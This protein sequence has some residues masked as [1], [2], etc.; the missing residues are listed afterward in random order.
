MATRLFFALLLLATGALQAQ[1]VVRATGHPNWPPFSWQQGDK[2]VGIGAELTELVFKDLGLT[3]SS[4]AHGNWKRAQL[5]VE[6]GKVDVIVAAYF[7]TERSKVM[8][9]P[10]QPYMNDANVLWVSKDNVFPFQQWSDLVDKTGTAMLG[11]SYGEAFDL[12]IKER[13][14]VEWVST[15]AQ[16]LGKLELGRADY[17]PFS[18]YGGQIQVRQL[19]FEGKITHL[20]TVLSTEGTYIAISRKSPLVARLPQIEAAIARLRADGTIDRLVRKYIDLA[21]RA[22]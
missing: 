18:L 21:A 20:P 5:E 1:T 22:Q 2:I 8:V 14:K 15:P 6:H 11:E 9:Y 3:V 4:K 10:A 17:Y 16:N 19:G 7:T 13:L 12:Y